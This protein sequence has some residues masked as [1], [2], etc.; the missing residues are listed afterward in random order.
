MGGRLF[1]RISAEGQEAQEAMIKLVE[2]VP[3]NWVWV[4]GRLQ[5]PE[6]LTASGEA[7][8][9]VGVRISAALPTIRGEGGFAGLP[10]VLAERKRFGFV[11]FEKAGGRSGVV[12][13]Q[14]AKRVAES[15]V[16]KGYRG[17]L[18][19]YRGSFYHSTDEFPARCSIRS[20]AWEGSPLSDD[21]PLA[22]PA[23]VRVDWEE[24]FGGSRDDVLRWIG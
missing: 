12:T 23:R 15:L 18:Q 13:F 21:E 7:A 1:F 3:E 6:R 10:D 2:A 14:L 8:A 11:E 16:R 5:A 9:T 4:D 20:K 17:D 19:F 24:Q 22:Q